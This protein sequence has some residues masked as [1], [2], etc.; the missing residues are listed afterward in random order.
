MSTYPFAAGLI[1][2]L[3]KDHRIHLPSITVLTDCAI[4]SYRIHETTDM[5]FV[6][7][8]LLKH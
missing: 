1:D 2:K 7:L 8:N 3:K 5:Y 6:G 4:H